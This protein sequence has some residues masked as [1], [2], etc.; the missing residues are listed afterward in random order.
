MDDPATIPKRLSTRPRDPGSGTPPREAFH[1]F[2]LDLQ[3][4]PT[5]PQFRG[6]HVFRDFVS[7][8]EADRLLE[9]IEKASF[10]PAQSGKLKQH[11]GPKVNFNKRKINTS[12]FQGLP[13]YARWIESR[14]R[15]LTNVDLPGSPK[16]ILALRTALEAFETTDAFVLRYLERDASN[17]D[18]HR[19]DTFAYGEAILDLSL[20]SDSVLTFLECRGQGLAVDQG[21]CVRVPLPARSLAVVYGRARSSWEH[22]ILAYDIA[23]RRTSITLRTLHETLRHS[24][25]GRRIFDIARG[26]SSPA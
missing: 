16:D 22:A 8:D 20:E 2:D 1:D 17:L 19:D 6:V 12:Q 4:S 18:F 3:L 13:E 26:H 7:A 10:V 11:Y 24:D 5:C 15:E 23:G 14:L 25:A 9:E 21:S